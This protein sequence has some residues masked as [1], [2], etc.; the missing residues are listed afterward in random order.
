MDPRKLVTALVAG[1]IGVGVC[2]LATCQAQHDVPPAHVLGANVP[3]PA[4]NDAS[5]TYV[6]TS[7]G[8]G[9]TPTWQPGIGSD[10]DAGVPT[11]AARNTPTDSHTLIHW[12]FDETPDANTGGSWLN[13][14]TGA[15][16]TLIPTG[17]TR[18]YNIEGLFNRAV[19]V[20]SQTNGSVGTGASTVEPSTSA[21]SW[22]MWVKMRT[23]Q[24]RANFALLLAKNYPDGGAASP[25]T[26]LAI[27]Q[28][29]A[30][31]GAWECQVAQPTGVSVATVV[32]SGNNEW[33][34]IAGNSGTAPSA[35]WQLLA[36]TFDQANGL[37]TAWR[38][39]RRANTLAGTVDASQGIDFGGHG[40][41]EVG[42]WTE[43][44][45]QGSD[46]L[47]DD[48]RIESVVR[49]PAA[50]AGVAAAVCPYYEAMYIRGLYLVAN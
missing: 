1:A 27:Y 47:V 43:G 7:N 3:I 30:Q 2:A 15:S 24:N 31:D 26:S 6:L 22:S 35:E 17:T 12:T 20:T 45:N 9:V 37:L 23:F 50:D 13:T 33:N 11:L 29:N 40:Q 46:V 10:Y 18:A 5:L 39:G 34:Y 16:A 25:Y 14:G 38:N 32:G 19:N 28:N 41:W 44:T 36:C 48:V 4:P 21:A 49:C 42:G 8:A